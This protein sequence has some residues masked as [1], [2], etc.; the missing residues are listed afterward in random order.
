M[1]QI[2]IVLLLLAF[3]SGCDVKTVPI[4]GDYQKSAFRFNDKK[5]EDAVWNKL[6][7][8][9]QQNHIA[10]DYADRNSGVITTGK[11]S[12]L[13]SY[14]CET[15][16]HQLKDPAAY[17][18]CARLRG[19]MTI[20]NSL[21]MQDVTGQWQ[22]RIKK[23]SESLSVDISLANATAVA[24]GTDISLWTK[25]K[26]RKLDKNMLVQSTGVFEK[27]VQAAIEQ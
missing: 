1:K 24:G 21:D 17:I 9:L 25:K 12:F 22:F 4:S 15:N 19:P 23:E 3:I 26:D 5:S 6:L 11:I 7:D 16:E 18:V 10:I 2:F 13:N 14:T 8:F 27:K 20:S